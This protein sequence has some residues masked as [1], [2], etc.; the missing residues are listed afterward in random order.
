MTQHHCITADH[1]THGH[2]F[3]CVSWN[4]VI[5]GALVGMGIAFLLNL[6]SMAIGLSLFT[7]SNAG[8]ISVAT[9]GFLGLLISGIISMFAA[10]MT[11]GYIGRSQ[12][13]NPNVGIIYGFVTWVVAL[14]FSA[15]ITS[16]LAQFTANYV[17]LVKNQAVVKVTENVRMP[18]LKS[19]TQDQETTKI[20]VN[21]RKATNAVG[22]ASL[23]TFILLFVGAI[24][25]C[26]GGY[27]GMGCNCYEK[28]KKS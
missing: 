18:A 24:S 9:G 3:F 28:K 20:Y 27:F 4:A 23:F 6:F 5:I 13:M 7:T 21:P 8:M 16:H 12:C 19:M 22:Y 2:Y 25:S 11:A 10:G 15:L 14:I 1:K 17:N 26:F